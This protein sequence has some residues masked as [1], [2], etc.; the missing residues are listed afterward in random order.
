M[1]HKHNND[2]RV[3]VS[4]YTF[5]NHFFRFKIFI[6]YVTV[7]TACMSVCLVALEVR[8]GDRSGPGVID[9]CE[10]PFRW[11]HLTGNCSCISE[12]QPEL[13]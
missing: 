3:C 7:L 9:H 5:K 4:I 13:S 10:P 6:L 12:E 8:E 2:T 1:V 11:M